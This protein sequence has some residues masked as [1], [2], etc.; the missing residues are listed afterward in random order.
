MQVMEEASG[1]CSN[2]AGQKLCHEE[3]S[4]MEIADLVNPEEAKETQEKGEPFMNISALPENPTALIQTY[5]SRQRMLEKEELC[6]IE[7]EKLRAQQQWEKQNCTNMAIEPST[8]EQDENTTVKA[9]LLDHIVSDQDIDEAKQENKSTVDGLQLLKEKEQEIERKTRQL[10]DRERELFNRERQHQQYSTTRGDQLKS[11]EEDL[12]TKEKRIEEKEKCLRDWEERNSRIQ[13]LLTETMKATKYR[14]QKLTAIANDLAKREEDLK[15]YYS[16]AKDRLSVDLP[17]KPESGT[18]QETQFVLQNKDSSESKGTQTNQMCEDKSEGT[19]EDQKEGAN[20]SHKEG[21]SKDQ[22][23]GTSKGQTHGTNEDQMEGT[24]TDQTDQISEYQIAGTSEDLIEGTSKNQTEGTSED[25]LKTVHNEVAKLE[26]EW[27]LT[28]NNPR[29]IQRAFEVNE[30]LISQSVE[31]LVS[32][33]DVLGSRGNVLPEIMTKER[34]MAEAHEKA[35]LDQANCEDPAAGFVKIHTDVAVQ[36]DPNSLAYLPPDAFKS[37]M[38]DT[39]IQ[40][41]TATHRSQGTQ[42]VEVDVQNVAVQTMMTTL[43]SQGSQVVEVGVQNDAVQTM[44]ITSH[45]SQGS[46]AGPTERRDAAVQVNLPCDPEFNQTMKQQ[47]AQQSGRIMTEMN[48]CTGKIITML[49][50]TKVSRIIE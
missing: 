11:K 37:C 23:V 19:R 8:Q 34:S 4:S 46:Q 48:N 40:T 41:M 26:A 6:T 12:N 15:I 1:I 44:I 17:N 2:V 49:H 27:L 36:T 39:A 29:K 9:L 50:T 5:L 20:K 14:I 21:T 32:P 24:S 22:K 45:R 18:S 25:Y 47:L 43:R 30:E 35:S 10:D 3:S 38:L 42:V 7:S 31:N 16:R 28:C 13:R 33:N